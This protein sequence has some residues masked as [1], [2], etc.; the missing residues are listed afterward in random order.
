M[1]YFS[2]YIFCI[3]YLSVPSTHDISILY[4]LN[5]EKPYRNFK[6]T[7]FNIQHINVF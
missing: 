5:V 7:L 3:K 4:F 6:M 2:N 1:L